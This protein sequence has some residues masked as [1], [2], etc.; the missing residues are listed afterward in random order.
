[1]YQR[2]KIEK[3]KLFRDT[4]FKVF[5]FQV[6]LSLIDVNAFSVA[7]DKMSEDNFTAGNFLKYTFWFMK[8]S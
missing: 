5:D 6:R 3:L 1:M 2:L 7:N 4:Y 8:M